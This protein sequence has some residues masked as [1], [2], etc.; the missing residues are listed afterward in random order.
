MEG[1]KKKTKRKSQRKKVS[2]TLKWLS[3]RGF[4]MRN[5]VKAGRH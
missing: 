5:V 1:G 4:E 2:L 3:E